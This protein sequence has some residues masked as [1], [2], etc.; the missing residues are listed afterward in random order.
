MPRVPLA[1]PQH[2]PNL[3]GQ[4]GVIS[5]DQGPKYSFF[6]KQAAGPFTCSYSGVR[7]GSVSNLYIQVCVLKNNEW[8]RFVSPPLRTR[9]GSDCPLF[10]W[11]PYCVIVDCNLY[12]MYVVGFVVCFNID[13][14]VFSTVQLPIIATS[15]FDYHISRSS[16]GILSFVHSDNKSLRTFILSSLKHGETTWSRLSENNF[17]SSFASFTEHPMWRQFFFGDDLDE[18]LHSMQIKS[19]STDSSFVIL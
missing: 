1:S 6:V 10:H 17:I 8:Y 2:T 14:S 19:S 16:F 12:K 4:F 15:C 5:I 11:D 9:P 13:N 18:G 7:F 3:Y